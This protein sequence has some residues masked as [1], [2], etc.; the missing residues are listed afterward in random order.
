MRA[1][2]EGVVALD[3]TDRG[4]NCGCEATSSKFRGG[5]EWGGGQGSRPFC[6]V[7]SSRPRRRGNRI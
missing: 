3:Q 5:W 1:E 2:E 4:G 6:R 7:K